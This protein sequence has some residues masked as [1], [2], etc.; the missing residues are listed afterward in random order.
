MKKPL[1][2]FLPLYVELYDLTTPEIRPDIDAFHEE[3]VKR[4]QEKGLEV[5]NVPV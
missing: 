1:I 3:V 4:L 2:G 5:I